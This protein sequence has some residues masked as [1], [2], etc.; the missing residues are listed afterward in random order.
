MTRVLYAVIIFLLLPAYSSAFDAT[1]LSRVLSGQDCTYCDLT[2]ASLESVNLSGAD[3]SSTNFSGANLRAANFRRADMTGADLSNT[4]LHGAILRNAVLDGVNLSGAKAAGADFRKASLVGAGL[5][6][7]D[8]YLADFEGANLDKTD[9]SR[10]LATIAD[11]N[12][13]LAL[14]CGATLP[15]GTSGVCGEAV[16]EATT[17]AGLTT[18]VATVDIEEVARTADT[19]FSARE[20]DQ[21][22][23][24]YKQASESGHGHSQSRLAYMYD[25]GLAVEV[26]QK[27]ALHWHSEA[28]KQN[29]EYSVNRAAELKE[30]LAEATDEIREAVVETA[31]DT[32]RRSRSLRWTL[33]RSQELPVTITAPR[34]LRRPFHFT[35]KP[36]RQAMANRKVG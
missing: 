3:V 29:I 36:L 21:A 18:E 2:N 33:R 15:D 31:A 13:T 19:H 28:A 25:A 20:F 16:V 27:M 12:L 10:A 6:K 4:I 22:F 14:L 17:D 34:N 1:H 26:D 5:D 23:P 9:L 35:N 11:A 7:A 24:L 30:K 8:L 32:S